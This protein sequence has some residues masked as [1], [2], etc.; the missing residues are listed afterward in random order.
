MTIPRHPHSRA[1]LPER[2]V[3]LGP[4]LPVARPPPARLHERPGAAARGVSKDVEHLQELVNGELEARLEV[5]G[6]FVEGECG[7]EVGGDPGDG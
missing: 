5:G 2:D 4:I 7:E 1:T 6:R 3:W